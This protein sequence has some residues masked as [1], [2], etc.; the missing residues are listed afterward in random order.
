MPE[1]QFEAAI[2]RPGELLEEMAKDGRRAAQGSFTGNQHPGSSRDMTTLRAVGV[3]RDQAASCSPRWQ[4]RGKE[5]ADRNTSGAYRAH[6][7]PSSSG[8]GGAQYQTSTV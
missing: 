1:A 8:V 4:G 2:K 5:R 3:P 7:S 6:R